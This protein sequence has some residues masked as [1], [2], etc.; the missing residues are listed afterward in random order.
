MSHFNSKYLKINGSTTDIV[1]LS[2]NG[3]HSIKIEN[4]EKGDEVYFKIVPDTN[5]DVQ[6]EISDCY[7]TLE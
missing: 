4:I 7:I 2:S 1:D 5:K 3:T 6:V